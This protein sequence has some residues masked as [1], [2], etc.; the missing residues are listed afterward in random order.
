MMTCQSQFPQEVL[1]L[2]THGYKKK[3]NWCDETFRHSTIFYTTVTILL[4]I[5]KNYQ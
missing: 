1:E 4:L 5:C 2:P 3:C